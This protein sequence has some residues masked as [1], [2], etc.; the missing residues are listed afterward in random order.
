MH[1]FAPLAQMFLPVA[2]ITIKQSKG[3]PKIP[4]VCQPLWEVNWPL[5]G[6]A[7][8][9]QVNIHIN[10]CVWPFCFCPSY[11]NLCIFLF[12]LSQ[13]P[14]ER[15]RIAKFIFP[16]IFKVLKPGQQSHSVAYLRS[17]MQSQKLPSPNNHDYFVLMYGFVKPGFT[18]L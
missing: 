7:V 13:S 18:I 14:S 12:F 11:T 10:T 3:C 9:F 15:S 2:S 8:P 5:Y 6:P 17:E 1:P 16:L 4:R